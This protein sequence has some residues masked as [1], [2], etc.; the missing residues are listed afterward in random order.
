MTKL[1][2]KFF[3]KYTDNFTSGIYRHRLHSALHCKHFYKNGFFTETY[4]IHSWTNTRWCSCRRYADSTN[5]MLQW[6]KHDK[7]LSVAIIS[8]WPTVFHWTW[9]FEPSRGVSSLPRN[10]NISVEFHRIWEMT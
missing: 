5:Q 1:V 4:L 8:V 9:N 3:K 10:F 7:R 6:T 2:E